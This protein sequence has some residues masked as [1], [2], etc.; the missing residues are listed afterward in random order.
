MYVYANVC[1]CMRMQAQA[2]MRIRVC[3][4]ERMSVWRD[5]L[6]AECQYDTE[7]ASR[8]HFVTY[9]IYCIYS[10]VISLIYI[11]FLT[12]LFLYFERTNYFKISI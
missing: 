6:L 5:A 8:Q 9:F 3:M 1:T 2:C 7:A 10:L 11:K 12:N 4:H